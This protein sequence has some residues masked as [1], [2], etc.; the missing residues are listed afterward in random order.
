MICLILSTVGIVFGLS[1]GE[2]PEKKQSLNT[3]QGRLKEAKLQNI[4]R[5]RNHPKLCSQNEF[6]LKQHIWIFSRSHA[7]PRHFKERGFPNCY[8]GGRQQHCIGAQGI[9]RV[10]TKPGISENLGQSSIRIIQNYI[11]DYTRL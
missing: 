9:C 7:N 1:G 11:L 5:Y 6:I 4:K 3:V 8:L 10:W 2:C